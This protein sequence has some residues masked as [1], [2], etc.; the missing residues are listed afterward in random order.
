MRADLELSRRI[1][2]WSVLSQDS[3]M[4]LYRMDGRSAIA[5]PRLVELLSIF[6][7]EEDVIPQYC[8][9][10]KGRTRIA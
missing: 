4:P 9:V 5:H 7:I 3:S 8:F 6:S 10:W 1:I 2:L